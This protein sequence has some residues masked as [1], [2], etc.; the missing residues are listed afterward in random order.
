MR[1]S[2]S[3]EMRYGYKRAEPGS[4]LDASTGKPVAIWPGGASVRPS[5]RDV[6]PD[7]HDSDV[8]GFPRRWSG[9]RVVALVLPCQVYS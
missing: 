4:G 7:I 8:K 2:G 3:V 6:E 1:T 9:V 5:F